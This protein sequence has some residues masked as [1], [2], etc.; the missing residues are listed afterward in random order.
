MQN[1]QEVFNRLQE[2]RRKIKEIKAQLNEAYMQVPEYVELKEK[3]KVIKEKIKGVRDDVN[4]GYPELITK[5]D[6]LKI[7]CASDQELLN[8]IALST[9]MKGSQVEIQN[10]FKQQVLPIFK[11]IFKKQD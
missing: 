10:E 4:L 1:A 11:V 8:D 7:D 2:N 9:M 5:L 6:D 3:H